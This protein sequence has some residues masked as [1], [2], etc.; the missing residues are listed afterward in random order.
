MS[1]V[2]P[3]GTWHL[4]AA[5]IPV[6]VS[7]SDNVRV[8]RVDFYFDGSYVYGEDVNKSAGT[9]V[10]SPDKLIL[11]STSTGSHTLRAVV[12]DSC[13]QQAE[14]TKTIY[15]TDKITI[16]V[17]S[18]G[19]GPSCALGCALVINPRYNAC[20]YQ[21]TMATSIGV[22]YYIYT[23][24]TDPSTGCLDSAV[25]LQRYGQL[26]CN[27]ATTT[28]TLYDLNG[29]KKAEV[30]GTTALKIINLFV[31]FRS[32]SM[33]VYSTGYCGL[34]CSLVVNPIQN[35]CYW[36]QT[37]AY[38][39]GDSNLLSTNFV[40]NPSTMCIDPTI[41]LQSYGT[42]VC[43]PDTR[44]CALIDNSGSMKAVATGATAERI[45]SLI[46]NG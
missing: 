34:G 36:Q 37:M 21:Q 7:Y 10:I 38:K 30:T 13:N 41:T 22:D 11:T 26:E 16:D 35:G 27:V 32:F 6:S 2:E 17:Y 44:T 1:F 42:L 18:T 28:C 33:S 5:T 3:A 29:A 23:R 4:Y 31:S 24:L 43:Y 45:M 14:A 19:S 39:I 9:L 25:T 12:K 46:G 15:I 20:Y 8:T 40:D